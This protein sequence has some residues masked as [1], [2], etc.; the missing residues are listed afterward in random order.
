MNKVLGVVSTFVD[1]LKPCSQHIVLIWLDALAG[2]LFV[3]MY[4]K[5]ELKNLEEFF[6]EGVLVKNAI[7]CFP[8]VSESAEGGVISGFYAGETNMLG[9]RYFSREQ[10]IMMHYKFNAKPE[11]DFARELKDCTIDALSKKS[12]GMGRLIHM[13][14]EEIVDIKAM[15]YERTG[16]LRIV[17]RRIEV[18]IN[19]IKVKKPRFFFF[20]ISA[21]YISHVDGRKGSSVYSFVKRFDEKFP[22][23]IQVLDEV[24]GR[25]SYTVVVFS[26]HGTASVSNHLDL[27]RFLEEQGFSPAPTDLIWRK[28][29]NCAALSNG[30]RSA[31][32]YFAHPNEGWRKR[33]GCKNLRKYPHRGREVDLLK[34]FAEE[35]GVAQVFAKRDEYSVIVV[36]SEGEAV[37]EYN[38]AE[39]KYRYRVIKGEDPLEYN[40][41]SKWMTEEEW[42]KMTYS[43]KYPDAVVQLYWIFKSPNCGDIVLNAS[44]KWDFWEPWDIWYPRLVA[45][46]GGLSRDEMSVF[47]LAKGPHIKAGVLPYA[48]VLDIYATLAKCFSGQIAKSHAVERMLAI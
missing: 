12:I 48:R 36:S 21:D 8:T 41:E 42:L 25:N 31:L 15:H 39:N 4:L 22:S 14:S 7:A 20:T 34:L 19:V 47:I 23:L 46:H 45:A 2:D 1:G 28:D 40:I 32:V 27:P 30:R 24:Y 9:E 18:A 29:S 17:D 35:R 43:K 33:P 38:R 26:D 5:G 11:A 13:A 3:E 10:Q 44:D 6:N 16:D 37:I